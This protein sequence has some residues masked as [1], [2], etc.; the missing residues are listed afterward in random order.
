ME[1]PDR[2]DANMALD[3]ADAS[4]LNVAELTRKDIKKLKKLKA[5][6]DMQISESAVVLSKSDGDIT[7]IE[8]DLHAMEA[9]GMLDAAPTK[10][11]LK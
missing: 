1:S 3:L 11:E 7:S 5:K 6:A 10:E 8:N 2:I 4:S 9:A